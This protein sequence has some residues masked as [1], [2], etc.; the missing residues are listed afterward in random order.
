[1]TVRVLIVD[2]H[3][4]TREALGSLLAAN[5]LVYAFGTARNF[6]SAPSI[7]AVDLMVAP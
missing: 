3:P 5:G 2:D 6:G 4:L 1:M 7:T